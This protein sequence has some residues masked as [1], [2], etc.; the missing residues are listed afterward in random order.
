MKKVNIIMF[1]LFFL[2]LASFFIDLNLIKKNRVL[3]DSLDSLHEITETKKLTKI[4]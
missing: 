2:I 4:L 1:V 3:S